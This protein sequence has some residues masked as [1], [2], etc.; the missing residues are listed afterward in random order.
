MAE[1]FDALTEAINK[2]N[3]NLE[4]KRANGTAKNEMQWDSFV[5]EY[6]AKVNELVEKQV[7][8]RMDKMPVRPGVAGEVVYAGVANE[9]KG[10]RY[11]NFIKSF[12]NGHAHKHGGQTIKPV[13]LAIAYQMLQGQTKHYNAQQGGVAVAP[14]ND[15]VMALKAMDSTTA[16][17]GDEYVPTNLRAQ[18]WEDFFLAS[19]VV[20]AMTRVDMPTN[21]FDIPLGL[22]EITWRKGTENTA[23]SQSNPST[24]KSTLT[25]NEHVAEQAWS[26]TLDE[27]SIIA[28]APAIRARLAQS[29]AEIMD[30]FVLNA[31]ATATSTGN[32]NLDDATP[33]ADSYYLS[34]GQDGVRH[35]WLV[36]NTAMGNSAGGDA[37]T[38]ADIT[39]LLAEMGKYAVDPNRLAIVADVSTYLNGFLKTGTGLPGEYVATLDKFG[40]SAIILT[41]QLAAYRG[42]PIIVSASH[43]LGQSDGKPNALSNTL[44]SF[45]VMNRDMWYVGFRRNLMMEVDRDIQRRQYIMVTSMR[46]AVAAHGTRATANHTGGVYNILV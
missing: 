39:T 26:Y 3:A 10:N 42:I 8:E 7:N 36:D 12:E 45:S 35:Q 37:L 33:A 43:P 9:L 22:G 16:T 25:V 19:R 1:K 27:D 21:P 46:Q 28:M 2:L 20:S 32:I 14:S 29:G 23:V 15:L 4:E 38:D 31:D 18:L 5:K 34:N 6:E 17:A 40:P 11:G 44:G 13:D 41:G 30:A 24:A